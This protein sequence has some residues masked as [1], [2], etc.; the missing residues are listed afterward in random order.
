MVTAYR[1]MRISQACI[2]VQKEY[3]HTVSHLRL[4]FL[5]VKY[6]S[7]G[8]DSCSALVGAGPFFNAFSVCLT[9]L[10]ASFD[11]DDLC[12]TKETFER[13]FDTSPVLSLAGG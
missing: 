9:A 1:D 7:Q 2:S 10:A 3:V 13:D 8:S 12:R 5:I 6:C 11:E 4:A